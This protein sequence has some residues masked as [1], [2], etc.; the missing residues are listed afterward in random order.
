MKTYTVMYTVLMNGNQYKYEVYNTEIEAY[1]AKD[2]L[3]KM[4]AQVWIEPS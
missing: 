2:R 1:K 4:M 3:S